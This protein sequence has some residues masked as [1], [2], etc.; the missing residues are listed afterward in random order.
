MSA[1]WRSPQARIQIFAKA[2]VPGQ[3]KTR[4]IPAVSAEQAAALHVQLVRKTLSMV[5]NARLCPVELW[6]APSK[7]DDFFKDCARDFKIWLR[8]QEGQDLGARMAHAFQAG[9]K[10]A[11]P[12]VLIGTD[13]P[14]LNEQDLLEALQVLNSGHDAVLGPA[15]D[16]GYYLIGLQQARPSLFKEIPWGSSTVFDQTLARMKASGLRSH[17]LRQ[18]W[19]LDR[20][21]DLLRLREAGIAIGEEEASFGRSI[22]PV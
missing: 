17:T 6:C 11:C 2:P 16:G 15:E 13:C 14:A 22:S 1:A 3:V 8:E 7:K 21:E 12:I 19:D 10:D 20:P 4:L 18:L 5:T 9:F